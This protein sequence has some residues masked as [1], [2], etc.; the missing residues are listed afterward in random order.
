MILASTESNEQS[1]NPSSH[2]LFSNIES[3]GRKKMAWELYN[4]KFEYSGMKFNYLKVTPVILKSLT[5][6]LGEG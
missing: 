5:N 4:M 6:F 3:D 2:C 1:Q